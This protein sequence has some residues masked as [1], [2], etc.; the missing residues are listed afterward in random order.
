MVDLNLL[1]DYMKKYL[2]K[3]GRKLISVLEEA[4]IPRANYYNRL[5]GK[6]EFTASEMYGIKRAT[7]MTEE[8]FRAIFFANAA[9]YNSAPMPS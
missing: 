8:I 5:K 2:K 3:S 4:G 1:E 6:G 7:E 9:E